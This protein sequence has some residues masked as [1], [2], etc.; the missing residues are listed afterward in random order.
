VTGIAGL[1]QF[2]L[3]SLFVL[4]APEARAN[5][6]TRAPDF[7][8]GRYAHL[9][10][11]LE[12]GRGLRFNNPYRLETV[13][14]DD[15][16]SLSLT[17][18]YLDLSAGAAFGPADGLQH[19]AALHLSFALH[20][21]P[22][23]VLTPSYVAMTRWTPFRFHARVGTPIV[24]EPDVN[25]GGEIAAGAAW[26]LTAGLGVGLELCASLFYGAAT[27]DRSVTAIPIVSLQGGLA[28]DYEI[29]P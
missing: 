6:R 20:G 7:E 10:G 17:A 5:G 15:A 16:E 12:I 27:Y 21:I 1:R 29:L 23:E 24:L 22:Q 8:R 3:L 13:L 25:V 14:G 18:T 19:G 9:F 28:V 26:L 2:A 11:G 4:L